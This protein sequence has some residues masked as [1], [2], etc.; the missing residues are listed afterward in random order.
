RQVTAGQLPRVLQDPRFGYRV[1]FEPPASGS[2]VVRRIDKEHK[3][4]TLSAG[5]TEQPLKFQLATSL[6]L[7]VLDR[8]KLLERILGA[9]PLKH[10]QTQRL[11]KVNLSNYFAGAL[12]L[13]YGDFF[14]EV[15]KS[16]Y[17]AELL[18]QIF[19]TTYETV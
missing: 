2:S 5:L 3:A 4:L 9:T 14:K 1:D 18:S 19:G 7:L 11:I 8:E 13:P 10:A 17:D 12:L 6:G 15:E 16:R